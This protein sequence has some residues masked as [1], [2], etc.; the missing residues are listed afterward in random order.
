MQMK[1]WKTNFMNTINP[2]YNIVKNNW[3]KELMNSKQ[4]Q[5]QQQIK[6]KTKWFIMLNKKA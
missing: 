2:E 3:M 1:E 6:W 4:K 5:L